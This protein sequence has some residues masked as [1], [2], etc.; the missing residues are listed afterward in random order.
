MRFS[1][2]FT[3]FLI[4]SCLA[5][6]GC[7][8]S[9]EVQQLKILYYNESKGVA[10][11]DPAYARN[12]S[13]IWVVNQ[14]YN[15][16]LQLDDSLN[17]RPC[18]AYRYSVSEDGK[19]YTFWLRQ[20]VYF[21]HSPIFPSGKGRQVTAHDFVYSFRRIL[22]PMVASPG[23]WI[24]GKINTQ[25]AEGGFEAVNDSVLKIYLHSSFPAFVG[26]LTMPYCFVVPHEAVEHFGKDF[27]SNPI[28]TGPFYLKRWVEGEKMVLLKNTQYFEKDQY[29][30]PLPYLDAV[31]ISF[32]VDKQSEFMEFMSG[33]IDFI[34]GVNPFFK[35]ELLTADGELQEKYKNKLNLLKSPYLNIEYLGILVDPNKPNTKNSPLMDKKVRQAINLA[36]D[37]EKM[38]KFLRNNIGYPAYAG[39]VPKGIPSFCDTFPKGYPY[40]P[41]SAKKILLQAGYTESKGFPVITLTT[42][43]DYADICEYVQHELSQ[44][45]IPVEIEVTNGLSYREMLANARMMM[46]RASWIADYPDA[47]SFLALFYSQN[48]SPLGPNYTHFRNTQFDQFYMQ[49]LA[50]KN[51]QQ[52][53]ELYRQMDQIIIDE[54]PVVPLF[55]DVAV[56]FTH[57]RIKNMRLNPLNLLVLKNVDIDIHK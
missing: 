28:G 19:E 1:N 36:I 48:F 52:R 17:I 50:E 18:I 25:K 46:F 56:R 6:I 47:E 13:V 26:I 55:Y 29:H 23:A 33:K 40:R 2:F 39:F 32:V 20:D 24:F 42:T 57:K 53:H 21:H 3:K 9:K 11:L 5:I 16:L 30:N 31:V 10:S 43:S 44:I 49:A 41:D 45:N 54:A 15:G 38:V 51:D 37:R 7:N 34:S 22:D 8:Q 12:Q 27:R 14:L 35:D 4:L